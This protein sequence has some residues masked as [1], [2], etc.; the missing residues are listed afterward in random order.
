MAT[1]DTPATESR[2]RDLR[3][4]TTQR[5]RGIP[6]INGYIFTPK[7]K[8]R[9]RFKCRTKCCPASII[10]REDQTGPYYIQRQSHNHPPHDVIIRRMEEQNELKQDV[11][12][13]GTSRVPTLEIAL[14]HRQKYP[15]S[16][17]L[18]TDLR[19]IRRV[20]Q[21][22]VVPKS[23]NDINPDDL[24]KDDIIFRSPDNTIMVFGSSELLISATSTTRVCIDGTF[25]R[26][27]KTH[28]QLLTCHAVCSDGFAF[29]FAFALL[30]NKRSTT[31]ST[32]FNEVD[33]K[34]SLLCGKAVFSR[35]DVVI[36]CDF[37]KGI[38][39]A[40]ETMHCSVRCCHFHFN[41]SLWRFMHKNGMS[42]RYIS[43][44]Q[45]R[46]RARALMVLPLFPE[47]E[48]VRVFEKLNNMFSSEDSDIRRLY[49]YFE[50][51]WIRSIPID[52]WCQYDSLFRTNNVAESFHATLSRRILNP[53]PQ[54]FSFVDVVHRLIGEALMKLHTQRVNPKTRIDRAESV[55]NSLKTLVDNHLNGPPLGL[56]LDELATVLFEKLHEKAACEELYE[57]TDDD[58]PDS[59]EVPMELVD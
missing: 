21:G 22:N 3:F 18:S 37:E 38:L 36:S 41:Q 58:E 6:V 34:A 7:D 52:C 12:A 29:P 46:S 4:V 42:S 10:V 43:D 40:A 57:C 28:Y 55:R 26:C 49:S 50:D 5:G 31:Y 30:A 53:H 1:P 54:F 8:E 48:I 35:N 19:F 44:T 27:P 20:R 2:H 24:P 25:S 33:R 16:R 14:E 56:P 15:T 39:K 13:K 45:F 47:N 23:C 17:R 59:S 9:K 11:L 51:V 32:V